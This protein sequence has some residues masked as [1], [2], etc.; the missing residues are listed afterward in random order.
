MVDFEDLSD[1]QKIQVAKGFDAVPDLIPFIP[2]LLQDLW[3]LGSSPSLIL[4]ILQMLNLPGNS[5]VLDLACGKG[6]VSCRIASQFKL[7]VVGI[8]LFKPFI[9]I[10]MKKARELYVDNLCSFEVRD[11]NNAV[12]HYKNF[13]LVILA[14]AESLLGEIG[15]AI[16]SLRGCVREEGY[17]IF[18][19]SFLLADAKITNPEYA[20]LRSYDETVEALTSRGDEII[21]EVIVP[22]EETKKINDEYTGLIRKRAGELAERFPDKKELLSGYV[23]KQTE[24]CKIIEEQLEGCIWCIRKG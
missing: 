15:N 20:V 16:D 8:D 13:D 2:F 21:Y 3:A 5:R 17:I 23:K 18:D 19:S 4:K 10:A 9:D 11:I 1:D 24:E 14:S 6:A 12:K 7:K 22:R